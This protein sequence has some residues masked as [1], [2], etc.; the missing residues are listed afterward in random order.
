MKKLRLVLI[1]LLFCVASFAQ[2]T[3]RNLL[4]SKFPSEIVKTNL[5]KQTDWHPFPKTTEEWQNALPENI[6]NLIIKKPKKP[7][8][9][10]F[11]NTRQR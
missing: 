1:I 8:R 7:P 10:K 4:S 11:R 5:I 2:I 9:K 3:Q 6:R